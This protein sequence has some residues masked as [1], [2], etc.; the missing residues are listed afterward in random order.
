VSPTT[1]WALVAAVPLVALAAVSLSFVLHS[2][3]SASPRDTST[4]TGITWAAGQERAPALALREPSGRPLSLAALRGRKA[5]VTFVDPHCTTF[6]PRESVVIDDALRTLPPAERPTVVAV[7]V[8][9]T[10]TSARVFAREARRFKWTAQWKWATGT[11]AQLR[12]AWRRY[13]IT[14]VPTPDDI[15]HTEAAYVIDAQ[16]YQR[17]LLLWPYRKPDL[18]RALASASS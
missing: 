12:D 2:S 10:V 4:D 14:V 5:I 17:A 13:H 9:P 16:G 1:R 18:L 7:S 11:A 6:C 3:S 8:D 15:T